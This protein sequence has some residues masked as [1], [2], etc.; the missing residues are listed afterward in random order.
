M[1]RPRRSATRSRSTPTSLFLEM[2]LTDSIAAQRTRRERCLVIRPRRT[3]VS[4]SW[5]LGVRPAQQVSFEAEANRV[6]S[7]ISATRTAPRVGPM[8]GIF[9]TAV[10]PGSWASRPRMMPANRLVSKPRSS[11]TWRSE[12]IRAAYGAGRSSPSNSS[13]PARPNR[14]LISTWTPHLASTA[15]TSA[16]QCERKP[17]QLGPVPDQLTQL[18]CGRGRDPRLGKAAHPQQV[19]QVLGVPKV[20]LDPAVLTCLDPQR[21]SQVHAGT[22]GLQPVHR[23]VPAVGGLQHHLRAVAGPGHHRRQPLHV[24]DDPHRLQH[25]TSFGGPD[26]HRPATVQIDSHKLFPCIRFH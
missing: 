20:V 6:M 1:L 21:V 18:P 3:W 24:I 14:S 25:L 9:C 16:L 23:P 4:D 7:P 15:C 13:V 2:V 5:C 19:R 11:I 17:D 10:Y 22:P 26:D 8:P 12:A